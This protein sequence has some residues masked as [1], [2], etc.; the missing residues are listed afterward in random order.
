MPSLANPHP[1]LNDGSRCQCKFAFTCF[2]PCKLHL[3]DGSQQVEMILTG[4]FGNLQRCHALSTHR[5]TSLNFIH[6]FVV[7]KLLIK[8]RV[9]A[10]VNYLKKNDDARDF[11][12]TINPSY[13]DSVAN[14]NYCR[15]N[16][17]KYLAFFLESAKNFLTF[18]MS[19][20]R[21]SE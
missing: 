11:H 16:S 3:A 13:T 17:D 9:Y 8:V 12:D 7:F 21:L 14:H 5:I 2:L 6:N 19:K 18:A 4:N 10:Y 1:L 15:N 20:P